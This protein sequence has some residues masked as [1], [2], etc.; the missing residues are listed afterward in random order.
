MNQFN[1]RAYGVLINENLE[2][3]VSDEYRFGSHFT[4]FPG[5]GVEFGEGI[6]DTIQREFLEEFELKVDVDD[7]FYVNDFLQIS[8]FDKTA[9]LFSFYHLISFKE[10]PHLE[11]STEYNKLTNEGEQLRWVAISNLEVE[12]FKFPIDQIVVQLIID[13]YKTY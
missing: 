6:K 4:K 12:Q 10:I 7:L 3:L 2:L 11:I 13:R 1:L 8:A 9:Q 5:G